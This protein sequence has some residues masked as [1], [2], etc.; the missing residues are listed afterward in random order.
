MAL[1]RLIKMGEI[2]K[3]GDKRNCCLNSPEKK[4]G[5]VGREKSRDGNSHGYIS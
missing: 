2:K 5:S 1:R 4:L 3:G